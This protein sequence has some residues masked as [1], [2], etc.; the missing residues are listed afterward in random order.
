MFRGHAK[1]DGATMRIFLFPY[2][3]VLP[4]GSSEFL[5]LLMGYSREILIFDFTGIGGQAAGWIYSS[6]YQLA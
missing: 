2:P 1:R 6:L 4:P 3:Q 5:D